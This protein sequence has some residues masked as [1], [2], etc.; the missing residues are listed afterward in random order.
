MCTERE[1]KI[2]VQ[3]LSH[4]WPTERMEPEASFGNACDLV[5]AGFRCGSGRFAV[6]VE[7]I[8]LPLGMMTWTAGLVADIGWWG[9]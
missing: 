3:A 1:L 4:I 9:N 7:V 5:V 6:A 2:V 8:M